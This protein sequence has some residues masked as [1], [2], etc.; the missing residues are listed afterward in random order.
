MV[1]MVSIKEFMASIGTVM[2]LAFV[3]CSMLSMGFSLTLRQ[4]LQPLRDFRMV[5]SALLVSFVLVP[6]LALFLIWAFPLPEDLAAGF[7]I[8]AF[9]AGCPFLPKLAHV[10]KGD[11]ALSVGLMVLLM[12]ATIVLAP[13]VLPLLIDDLD[14]GAWELARSLITLLLLPLAFSLFV[15]ARYGEVADRLAPLMAQ[16]ANFS[17]AILVIAVF[18]AYFDY[19]ASVIGTTAIL[20][21][22]VFALLAFALGWG[23]GGRDVNKKKVLALGA[24]YRNVSAALAIGATSFEGINELVMILVVSLMGMVI[25]MLIGGELAKRYPSAT[26]G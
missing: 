9:C 17:L 22:L 11:M 16:V 18:V 19:L 8:V 23:M 14:I 10:A 7:L 25:L 12:M 24:A 15:K 20:V 26:Q 4:I 6:L 3:V 21:S 5:A 13:L 2:G 1:D